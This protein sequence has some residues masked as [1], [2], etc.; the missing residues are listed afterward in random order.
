MRIQPT[1]ANTTCRVALSN[2]P[3][4][5]VQLCRCPSDRDA[6]GMRRGAAGTAMTLILGGAPTTSH[7]AC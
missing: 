4:L 3:S 5:S 2:K 6:P 1:A 7:V